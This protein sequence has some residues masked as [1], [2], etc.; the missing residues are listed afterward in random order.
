[1]TEAQLK[2]AVERET[3]RRA[4]IARAQLVDERPRWSLEEFCGDHAAQLAACRDR[5]NWIHLL[6]DRQSGKT[7]ADMGILLDNAIA[8]PNSVNVFLGLVGVGLELS[9]W[10]KWKQLLDKYNIER[11]DD[12]SL[13]TSYFTNGA[14]VAF[15]GT[16]DREH[17][18]RFLG[19]RLHNSVFIVDESQDQ[20]SSIL[21]YLFEQLLPPMMTPT[22]R[23]IMSGVLPDLPVGYFLDRA[24]FD[25]ESKTGGKGKKW[26]H[27]SWGRLNNP[28]TPEAATMLAALEAEKGA[29]DPQLMR[30]WKGVKRVWDTSLTAYRY[31]PA[32]DQWTGVPCDW[33]LA[34]MLLP[35]RL[36]AVV[37]PKGIDR[38]AIGLDPAA[39]ADRFAIVLWGWS[40]TTPM[41]LWQ[42]AEW[43]TARG[44]NALES[45]YL[46]VIKVLKAKYAPWGTIGRVIRDAGSSR[47]TN[48]LLWQSHNIMIEPAI[49]GPGSLR[50][51]VDRLADVLGTGQGH[52]L[53][54]SELEND[55]KLAKWSLR[56]R[57][58]GRWEFDGSHHPDVADAGTY[59]AVAFY[60][61]AEKPV[62]REDVPEDV[63][64][65]REAEEAERQRWKEAVAPPM[66]RPRDSSAL[67][68]RRSGF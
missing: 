35:G 61:T 8:N 49:K 58:E 66:A 47:T 29:E 4:A 51:R 12:E 3:K 25:V 21:T 38:F 54:G 2:R 9:V 23:V 22:T 43:V 53:A 46:E 40:S 67:W 68:G 20:P 60:E 45:Q 6:C 42:I 1:V 11:S 33:A 24:T 32:R 16:T 59:G 28:F 64:L 50:A 52:I 39:T 36:I 30:D 14:M 5:S 65:A 26:S 31:K 17:I 7:W 48:D 63:A 55:L 18:K 15:A 41:G 57:E 34:D 44:A 62:K 37:P 13:R 10:P 56:A 27:H 19:N